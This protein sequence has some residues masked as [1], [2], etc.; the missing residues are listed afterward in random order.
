MEEVRELASLLSTFG[1]ASGLVMNVNE[2][3]CFP[4]RCEELDVP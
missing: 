4:I 1:L 3:A 2:R